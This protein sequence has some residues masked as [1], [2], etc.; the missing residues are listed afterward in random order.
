M[1][2][3]QYLRFSVK[4]PVVFKGTNIAGEGA[5]YNISA[6]GCM[7]EG[8]QEVE[9]GAVLA[10]SIRM[11]D[12]EPPLMVAQASVQWVMRQKFGLKFLQLE[13]QEKARLRQWIK[14]LEK[15]AQA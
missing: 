4:V 11:A 14:S 15:T 1:Q 10:L 9:Q 12:Q 3:R 5:V 13:E 2:L 8:N 6:G 7:I